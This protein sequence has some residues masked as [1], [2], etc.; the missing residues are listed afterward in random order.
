MKAS[1]LGVL[2]ALSLIGVLIWARPG[3][4]APLIGQPAPDFA[5]ALVAGQGSE[6]GDRVRLSDLKGR[7]VLL[8]FWASWCGPCRLSVPLLNR[9][10]REFAGSGLHV[11]GINSEGLSPVRVEGVASRW[12]FTYPVL[13]DPTAQAE[14]AYGISA[15]PTLV[16]IDRAGVVRQL[17]AGAPSAER[18]LKEIRDVDR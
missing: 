18:L 11:Y 5:L 10:A 1:R 16:L 2:A 8:D 4:R 15:V 3:E 14:L 12:G 9:V 13:H 7:P 6:R 17:Y